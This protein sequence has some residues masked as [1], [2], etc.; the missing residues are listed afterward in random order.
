MDFCFTLA[1]YAAIYAEM[2]PPLDASVFARRYTPPLAPEPPPLRLK[3][4][5]P[6]GTGSMGTR[7]QTLFAKA[8]RLT[9]GFACPTP[10][11]RL[12]GDVY[13][14]PAT[15]T[16]RRRPPDGGG[17]RTPSPP[18]RCAAPY[19][20]V[21]HVTIVAHVT[22]SASDVSREARTPPRLFACL[23]PL[24]RC[25]ARLPACLPACLSTRCLPARPL[26]RSPVAATPSTTA[27]ALAPSRA[28]RAPALCAARPEGVPRRPRHLDEGVRVQAR[29]QAD[30][31]AHDG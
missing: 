21:P 6:L 29:P 9:Q 30:A 16:F 28:C 22:I 5:P 12:W 15:R 3:P 26:A 11:H 7:T 23:C 25:P 19:E 17:P 20:R 2:H 31:Q 24:A 27:I 1:S 13:L 8:A 10:R 18:R 14:Q 4:Q